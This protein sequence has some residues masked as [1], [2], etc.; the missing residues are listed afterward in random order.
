M[1]GVYGDFIEYF[2]EL[3]EVHTVWTAPDKSDIRKIQA[4][5]IPTEG[6][7]LRRRKYTSGNTAH[8]VQDKDLIYV[9]AVFRNKIKV[10]DYIQ[11]DGDPY[12]MRVTGDVPFTKAA[13]YM[14]FT[15]ERVTGSTPDKNKPLGVKEGYFA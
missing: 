12:F 5:Y 14:V 6:D 3:Y 8:D 4:V 15:V 2:Q 10:G 13:G 11:K 7:T 9:S 1:N